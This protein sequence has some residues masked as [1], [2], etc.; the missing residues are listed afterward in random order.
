MAL[1]MYTIPTEGVVG[2][3]HRRWRGLA[4]RLEANGE[5][6]A[7]IAKI[8]DCLSANPADAPMVVEIAFRPAVVARFAAAAQLLADTGQ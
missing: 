1:S 2:M 3:T 5:A 7:L 4:N 8:R 6:P